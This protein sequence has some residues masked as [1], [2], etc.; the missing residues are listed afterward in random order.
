MAATLAARSESVWRSLAQVGATR[1]GCYS[2]DWLDNNGPPSA[3]H[4]VPEWQSLEEGRT[5]CRGA[6]TVD[7]GRRGT[8][9]ARRCDLSAAGRESKPPSAE[10]W[11]GLELT[12]KPLH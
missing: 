3:E 6:Q 7:R 4:I 5:G 12:V 8:R 9:V 1:G 10:H 11:G 2:W